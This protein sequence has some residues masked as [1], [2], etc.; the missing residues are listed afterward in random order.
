ML[1]ALAPRGRGAPHVAARRPAGVRVALARMSPGCLKTVL[2]RRVINI[3]LLQFLLLGPGL[4]AAHLASLPVQEEARG[5]KKEAALKRLLCRSTRAATSRPLIRASASRGMDAA[6]Q[7][8][9]AAH[10]AGAELR[11]LFGGAVV[12]ALP[13]TFVVRA[14]TACATRARGALTA[15]AGRQD[16]STLR[17]VPDNQE[18]WADSDSDASLII[19]LVEPRDAPSCVTAQHR[20]AGQTRRC[21]HITL[22]VARC[23]LRLRCYSRLLSSWLPRHAP[24]ALRLLRRA[25]A[26]RRA[27][28]ATRAMRLSRACRTPRATKSR[29]AARSTIRGGGHARA[30][31][32]RTRTVSAAAVSGA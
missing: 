13:S 19:E 2:A 15:P 23:A 26:R 22:R 16:V 30:R 24:V 7:P 3:R 31:S 9:A 11:Q 21:A 32:R 25:R 20:R 18:V 17:Q 10:A 1:A 8:A 4:G 27:G 6:H 14:A 5:S 12:A 28:I 29:L